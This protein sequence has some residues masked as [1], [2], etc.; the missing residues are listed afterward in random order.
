MSAATIFTATYAAR[1]ALKHTGSTAVSEEV[2]EPKTEV[3]TERK[4][5]VSRIRAAFRK[6]KAREL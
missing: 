4:S 6:E 3:K 2:R 1:R 5:L